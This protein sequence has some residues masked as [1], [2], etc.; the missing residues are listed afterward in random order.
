MHDAIQYLQPAG[1]PEPK[2]H[3]SPG[4]AYEGLVFVS[5]QLPVPKPESR[6][7][8]VM[9]QRYGR[10]ASLASSRHSLTVKA[11]RQASKPSTLASHP[12]L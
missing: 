11:I 8:A 3:Y 10:C 9:I 5:G 2:G 1:Q 4:V 12:K 7:R 6:L